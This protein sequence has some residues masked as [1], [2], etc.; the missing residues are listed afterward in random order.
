MSHGKSKSK[1]KRNIIGNDESRKK[2]ETAILPSE[3]VPSII[4]Q[5]NNVV[6]GGR[7]TLLASKLEQKET[8]K[9]RIS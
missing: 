9:T 6:Y 7:Y 8:M 1:K 5:S 4:F 3:H 2:K